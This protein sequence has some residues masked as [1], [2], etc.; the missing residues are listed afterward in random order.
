MQSSNEDIV[1]KLN[2]IADKV[3]V[4]Y[5]PEPFYSVG[6]FYERFEQVEDAGVKE[7]IKR[8]GYRPM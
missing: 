1:S 2:H 8:H 3:I 7:I 6:Q 5:R 4:L